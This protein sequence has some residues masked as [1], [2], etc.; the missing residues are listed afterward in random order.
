MEETKKIKWHLLSFHLS[1]IMKHS[2]ITE[3]LPEIDECC[4]AIKNQ[5]WFKSIVFS[6]IEKILA[7]SL[8]RNKYEICSRSIDE[9]IGGIGLMDVSYNGGIDIYAF[10]LTTKATKDK[11]YNLEIALIDSFVGNRSIPRVS[12]YPLNCV[13]DK[14]QYPKIHFYTSQ[15]YDNVLS[16]DSVVEYKKERVHKVF[17]FQTEELKVIKTE[18]IEQNARGGIC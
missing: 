6:Y 8:F 9:S 1:E 16:G 11:K 3:D 10:K 18:R 14:I 12:E 2:I 4:L 13:T 15:H 7:K 5:Y 17:D